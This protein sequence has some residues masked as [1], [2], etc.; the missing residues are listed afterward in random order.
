MHFT[1]ADKD[2]SSNNTLEDAGFRNANISTGDNIE[3]LNGENSAS[4]TTEIFAFC[5]AISAQTATNQANFT[6]MVEIF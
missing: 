5:K 3:L 2:R 6:K 1:E 4:V